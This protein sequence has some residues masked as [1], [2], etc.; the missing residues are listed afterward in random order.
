MKNA[1]GSPARWNEGPPPSNKKPYEEIKISTKV[2]TWAIT[3]ASG[4]F[5]GQ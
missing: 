4:I 1:K 3:K 5:N 2:N